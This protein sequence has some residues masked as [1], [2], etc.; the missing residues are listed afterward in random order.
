MY[1]T[2]NLCEISVKNSPVTVTN[3]LH[4]GVAL[5]IFCVLNASILFHI[6]LL[7]CNISIIKFFAYYNNIQKGNMPIAQ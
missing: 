5:E 7:L 6:C 4:C 3:F 2:Q 1:I